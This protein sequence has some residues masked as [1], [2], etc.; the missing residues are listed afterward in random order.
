MHHAARPELGV[1]YPLRARKTVHGQTKANGRRTGGARNVF[2]LK[3]A[4]I[5]DSADMG[6]CGS[7]R[8][9]GARVEVELAGRGR[10][11]GFAGVKT[12]GGARAEEY[13]LTFCGETFWLERVGDVFSNI[14]PDEKVERASSDGEAGAPGEVGECGLGTGYGRAEARRRG[15]GRVEMAKND[16]GGIDM[17]GNGR[18]DGGKRL[19]ES[20]SYTSSHDSSNSSSEDDS[21]D[22]TD[23]STDEE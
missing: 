12:G 7:V 10:G 21:D 6:S 8:R 14:R 19:R 18:G 5:P 17:C 16:G 11:A 9:D 2:A 13:L 22:Y 20:F 4:H 1:S 3:F 15:E 23:R